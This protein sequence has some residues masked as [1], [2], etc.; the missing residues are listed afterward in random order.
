M[1]KLVRNKIGRRVY[2]WPKKPE[3]VGFKVRRPEHPDTFI[4]MLKAKLIEEA[5]EVSETRKKSG[6]WTDTI[7]ELGDV[8]EV[9]R[10]MGKEMGFTMDDVILAA[11]YKRMTLGDFSHQW[12]LTDELGH[13]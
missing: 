4:D 3:N 2:D 10:S 7:V 9:M 5:E 1:R 12:V 11:N 6:E 8:Y 13:K